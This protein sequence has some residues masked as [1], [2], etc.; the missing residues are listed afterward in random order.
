M[1]PVVES[2]SD[3]LP[4][5]WADIQLTAFDHVE[6]FPEATLSNYSRCLFAKACFQSENRL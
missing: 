3:E 4:F 2:L 6:P 5:L 1:A